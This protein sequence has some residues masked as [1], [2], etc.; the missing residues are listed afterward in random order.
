MVRGASGPPASG[1]R[2][3]RH[4]ECPRCRTQL[5]D[6]ISMGVAEVAR[7][8][9]GMT[10]RISIGCIARPACPNPVEAGP[11]LVAAAHP[12]RAIC[13][14][15]QRRFRTIPLASHQR[16]D[17]GRSRRRGNCPHLPTY[18]CRATS[19]SWYLPA[20]WHPPRRPVGL[21]PTDL[22][23]GEGPGPTAAVDTGLRR[24]DGV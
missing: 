8:Y 3:S 19:T 2:V 24:Y 17:P 18:G 16:T 20:A 15:A 1:R 5:C 11:T 13:S 23:R 10:C 6:Q 12:D 4:Q 7:G 22:F 14:P 21:Q 9:R